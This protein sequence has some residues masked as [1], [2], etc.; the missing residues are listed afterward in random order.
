MESLYIVMPAYNEEANIGATV[1][2]WYPIIRHL[3]KDGD[4]GSRLVVV[5]DGSRDNTL[6]IL[7]QLE[8]SLPYLT[9]IDK[10]N[11]G[12]GSAVLTGYR[13]AIEKHA[14]YIFQT[15]SDGQTNPR[16][17]PAFWAR[18]HTYDAV[19][20][21]RSHREDGASRVFVENTLR[22]IL[23]LTFGVS[24]PD[25]NAPFRLMRTSL[26]ARYLPR[27]S[28]DFN[29]P[30]VML[31]TFFAYYHENIVFREISFRPRTRGTNSI[32]MKR[33]AKI[34][35]QAV[36]DFLKIRLAM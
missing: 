17:F 8:S 4:S 10:P 19:I 24:V 35:M 28:E 34:G 7:R 33:I 15:D 23:L 3:N 30:N 9:V 11:G 14:D 13:Y 16:E 31:T 21:N 20:G 12:H 25:S 32:N 6:S 29:L 18:R 5:N 36:R 2:D 27:M 22:F 26:V 1:S